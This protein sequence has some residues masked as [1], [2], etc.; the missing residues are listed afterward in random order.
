MLFRS[1]R[2]LRKGIT[3][4][5]K[6]RLGQTISTQEVRR[7][8]KMRVVQPLSSEPEDSGDTTLNR[9]TETDGLARPRNE[10]QETVVQ[11]PVTSTISKR[12][13]AKSPT[14]N[15][16]K[17]RM[18]GRSEKAPNQLTSVIKMHQEFVS[19]QATEDTPKGTTSSLEEPQPGLPTAP[20][21]K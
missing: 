10:R 17:P 16:L 19:A 8:S 9:E 20:H 11:A 12:N 5:P 6:G 15:A 3:G 1:E 2:F 14:L 13:S 18:T 4:R 7:G 21:S